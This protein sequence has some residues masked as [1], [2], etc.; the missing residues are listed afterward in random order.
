V[1][2]PQS[3]VNNHHRNNLNNNNNNNSNN[4]NSRS[5]NVKIKH[6]TSFYQ[7]RWKERIVQT[8]AVVTIPSDFVTETVIPFLVAATA[9][10][11]G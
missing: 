2:S 4:P 6:P 9:E 8:T 11:F 3:S 1:I 10:I 7:F 5:N